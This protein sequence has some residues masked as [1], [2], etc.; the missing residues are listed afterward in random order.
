MPP[1][2]KEFTLAKPRPIGTVAKPTK[3]SAVAD[4][5]ITPKKKTKKIPQNL[6]ESIREGVQLEREGLPGF[7]SSQFRKQ[8]CRHLLTVSRGLIEA[9]KK[10]FPKIIDSNKE[11]F[12]YREMGSPDSVLLK[13]P[14]LKK[15]SLGLTAESSLPTS[16]LEQIITFFQNHFYKYSNK[17]NK[18]TPVKARADILRA[19]GATEAQVYDKAVEILKKDYP[20]IIKKINSFKTKKRIELEALPENKLSQYEKQYQKELKTVIPNFLGTIKKP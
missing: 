6:K 15:T 13:N 4:I 8:T 10:G 20:T 11:K 17:F 12:V 14:K 18:E 7:E 5:K 1:K 19:C 3:K 16:Q 9:E 2:K